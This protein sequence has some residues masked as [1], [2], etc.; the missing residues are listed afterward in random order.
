MRGQAMKS[1][2]AHLIKMNEPIN[3]Y[4]ALEFFARAGDWQTCVYAPYVKKLSAWEIDPSFE[5]DLRKNLPAA[6]IRIGDSYKMA[7]EKQYQ[8][9]FG[10]IVF[11]NPQN[12]FAGYCEHFEALPLVSQLLAGRGVVVFNINHHPFNYEKSPEW[13]KRRKEY[14]GRDASALDI[15][16]LLNF[17]ADKFNQMGLKVRFVL[18]EPR[19]VEY[20][21]YLVYGLEKTDDPH[22]SQI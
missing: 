14:Y 20:L 5:A 9:A 10:L 13:Q 11:D 1:L 12:V 21:S 4:H 17:Y 6:E 16:F 3:E 19:N 22:P 8:G 18:E 15:A 2:C 7:Y